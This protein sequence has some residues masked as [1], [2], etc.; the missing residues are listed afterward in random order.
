[1]SRSVEPTFPAPLTLDQTRHQRPG[2]S[3]HRLDSDEIT[4]S[5]SNKRYDDTED[6]AGPNQIQEFDG[7]TFP[8][9]SAIFYPTRRNSDVGSPGLD[10]HETVHLERVPG[11]GHFE[12][13]YAISVGENDT[14]LP[15]VL[16]HYQTAVNPQYHQI[17]TWADSDLS[18]W[19]GLYNPPAQPETA[20]E[21]GLD[22]GV[23]DNNN[24][25]RSV[26]IPQGEV[27]P[28]DFL[29]PVFEE[30]WSMYNRRIE[31]DSILEDAPTSQSLD[32]MR[33]DGSHPLISSDQSDSY[34]DMPE[35]A[36]AEDIKGSRDST[37]GYRDAQFL[38]N[39]QMHRQ[40]TPDAVPFRYRVERE[41][42]QLESSDSPST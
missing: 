27:L 6:N 26:F 18:N 30:V 4:A 31:E 14:S 22:E 40:E 17:Q 8:H 32:S 5:P 33:A 35:T 9:Y 34:L 24:D 37:W 15:I 2:Q 28:E 23:T 1:M 20:G 21:I 38:S 29:E 7:D 39:F 25:D 42:S 36:S 41:R 3:Q 16:P 12:E 10:E 13:D 11:Y 19:H